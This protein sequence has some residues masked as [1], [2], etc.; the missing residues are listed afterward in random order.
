MVCTLAK[1][2]KQYPQL[3]YNGLGISLKLECQYLKST[4]HEVGTIMSPI[5]DSLR[6]AFF[7]TLFKGK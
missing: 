7:L 2:S 6:E 5:K 3:V 4:V 1:I